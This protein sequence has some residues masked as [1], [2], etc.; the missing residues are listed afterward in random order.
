MFDTTL[1]ECQAI[2]LKSRPLVQFDTQMMIISENVNKE[3]LEA[4]KISLMEKVQDGIINWRCTVCGKTAK[5][6]QNMKTHIETHLEGLSYTCNQCGK[7][8]RSSNALNA[9]VSTY[10]RNL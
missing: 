10:H 2:S 5:T 3:E 6:A 1:E 8:S 7:V 9:H 4:K